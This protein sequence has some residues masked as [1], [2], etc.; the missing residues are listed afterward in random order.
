MVMSFLY[1]ERGSYWLARVRYVV[2]E[3]AVGLIQI[4]PMWT[5]IVV[6]ASAL[7]LGR[8]RP[9]P[10]GMIAWPLIASL[11]SSTFMPLL[12]S[13]FNHGV[14][15][16]VHPLT[17]AVCAMSIVFPV[18]SFASLYCAV[19]WSVRADRPHLLV[20]LLPSAAALALAGLA[21]WFTANGLFAFRTWAW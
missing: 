10:L 11:S 18:A 13:A 1:A 2:L 4:V 20:R 17:L 12:F 14:I 5:V 21:L 9:V 19:R 15:G 6:I 7:G 3:I 16:V 8:R